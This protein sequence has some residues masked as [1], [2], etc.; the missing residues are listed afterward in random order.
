MIA[1]IPVS[2]VC[3]DSS[4]SFLIILCLSN[5]W[6][7]TQFV[8]DVINTCLQDKVVVPKIVVLGKVLSCDCAISTLTHAQYVVNFVVSHAK[9]SQIAE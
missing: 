9:Y 6:G 5:V 4:V 1:K 7:T 8:P 2:N 3:D